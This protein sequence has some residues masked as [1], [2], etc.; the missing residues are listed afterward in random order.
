MTATL[1]RP[2]TPQVAGRVATEPARHR[3][4]VALIAIVV[5]GSILRVWNL[6][7]SRLNYDESFTAMA[8]RL[9]ISHLFGFLARNDSHPPLDYLLHLPLARAGVSEFWFRLPSA[10]FSVAALALFAWWVRPRGR[11]AVIATALMAVS[12]FQLAHGR[13]ARMYAELEFLG[14]AIAVL[15]S[16][17]I[18]RPKRWHAPVLGLAVFAGLMTHVSMFLLAAGLLTLAGRRT[19]RHAWRWRGAIAAAGLAW[20]A[21][22]GSTFAEQARGGHS[23]WIPS[24]T[25]TTLTT[26]LARLV[27]YDPALPLVVVAAAAIGA[28]II[29]RTDRPLG[30][31]LVA[32]LAVPV[33]LAAVAGLF[34]PVVL[35]RTFTLMAWAPIVGVA[36]AIDALLRR[37]RVLGVAVIAAGLCLAVP[38]A[39]GVVN[40]VAGPD[41]P[42]R[43]LA[44]RMQPGDIVAVRPRSKAPELQWTL[45]VRTASSPA[46]VRVPGVPRA[47][48]LR[49]GRA[50]LTGRVFLLDWKHHHLSAAMRTSSCAPRW[51]WGNTSI[52]CLR[53]PL[54]I[55]AYPAT[56]E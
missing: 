13:D 56:L 23:S 20:L 47:F 43:A 45:G 14:V 30:R 50:E 44:A 28:V 27:S 48:A 55:S 52:R 38:S 16:A 24:T 7:A 19:D 33:G 46:R 53:I 8:G 17:W 1:T 25:L 2:A 26:A 39:L 4:D 41:T 15:A 5:V 49:V 22:W 54:S 3:T 10:M 29:W 51:S 18:V 40:R 11:V 42:L 34:E 6:G 37:Q 36:V 9:P 32:V 12:A 21:L 31:V 35:D